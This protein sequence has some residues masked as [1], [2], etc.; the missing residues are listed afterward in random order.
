MQVQCPDCETPFDA[1][2]GREVVCPACMSP[3]N[4]PGE[5]DAQAPAVLPDGAPIGKDSGTRYHGHTGGRSY[6]VQTA[7]GGLINGLSRYAVREAV[8]LGRFS[9]AAKLRRV[10]GSWEAIGANSEFAAVF[11]LMGQDP[12]PAP[13]SRKISSWKGDKVEEEAPAPVRTLKAVPMAPPSAT[14]LA[15]AR[16]RRLLVGLGIGGLLLLLL[17]GLFFIFS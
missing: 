16:D 13:A 2:P 12:N 17:L 11:R 6:D 4:S 14:A 5:A 9:N 8:Y 7:E 3:F 10:D 1:L 15:R